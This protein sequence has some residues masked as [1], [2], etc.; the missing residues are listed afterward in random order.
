MATAT[1]TEIQSYTIITTEANAVV[2]KVH[3]RM[4]VIL[5]KNDEETWLNPDIT[6]P[7]HLLPLLVPYPA[8]KM[9]S[10]RVGQAVWNSRIDTPE[11]IKPFEQLG[12]EEMGSK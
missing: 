6:E 10:Y 1:G 4:P 2:G 12:L 3:L 5:H 9:T 7:E 11:L 8:E